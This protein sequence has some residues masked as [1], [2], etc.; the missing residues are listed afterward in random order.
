MRFSR[1][2][3]KLD[4]NGIPKPKKMALTKNQ[5]DCYT[6]FVCPGQHVCVLATLHTT[7]YHQFT[8]KDIVM[9]IAT[10]STI[11]V[12]TNI[13]AIEMKNDINQVHLLGTESKKTVCRSR[14]GV[15]IKPGETLSIDAA[16]FF[17]PEEVAYCASSSKIIPHITLQP[18]ETFTITVV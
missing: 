10:G 14:P 16:K 17:V 9:T 12:V 6:F 13:E 8:Q 11:H 5:A 4:L 18:N 2:I 1:L 3:Y 7:S 15:V